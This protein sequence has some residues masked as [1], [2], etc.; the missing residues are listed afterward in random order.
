MSIAELFTFKRCAIAII[1]ILAAALVGFKLFNYYKSTKQ[2][3][4][5]QTPKPIEPAK[6]TKGPTLKSL[7]SFW[8]KTNGTVEEKFEVAVRTLA[9]NSKVSAATTKDF[10]GLVNI[11]AESNGL[12]RKSS[13]K[14]VPIDHV[15]DPV[16]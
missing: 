3:A 13:P 9:P 16:E 5:K 1:A 15:G 12:K 10:S 8:N 6:P 14:L 7:I 4:V 11:L 2:A